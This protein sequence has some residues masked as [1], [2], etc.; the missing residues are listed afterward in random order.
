[1][2]DKC[3][4]VNDGWYCVS[5]GYL[6]MFRHLHACYNNSRREVRIWA[7]IEFDMDSDIPQRVLGYDP[8]VSEVDVDVVSA[9]KNV[10]GF[11][12][13]AVKRAKKKEFLISLECGG[14][15]VTAMLDDCAV[16][17]CVSFKH[18]N[19]IPRLARLLSVISPSMAFKVMLSYAKKTG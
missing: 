11:V 4:E 14:G 15:G 5:T 8:E 7:T 16:S 6:C 2:L 19:A 18:P 9:V 17:L 12:E 13:K 3:L 1:M 10:F